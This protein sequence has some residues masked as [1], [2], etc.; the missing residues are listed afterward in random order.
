MPAE[1][2][3]DHLSQRLATGVDRDAWV[4]GVPLDAPVALRLLD[5]AERGQPA[6]PPRGL[7]D[8]AP[9]RLPVPTRTDICAGLALLASVRAEADRQELL[10]ISGARRRGVTWEQLAGLLGVNTRQAAEQRFNRL[11]DRYRDE[12]KALP[13]VFP[14][15]AL[16]DGVIDIPQPGYLRDPAAL[17]PASL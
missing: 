4:A 14:P 15:A 3:R 12:A 7:Y 11:A 1:T 17:E 8:D 2:A 16:D 10:L 5:R 6:Y 9:P 13:Q